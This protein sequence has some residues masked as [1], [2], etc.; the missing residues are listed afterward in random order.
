MIQRIFYPGRFRLSTLLTVVMND[1]PQ[2][3]RSQKFA[4]IKSV[5]LEDSETLAFIISEVLITCLKW[6]AD[7]ITESLI[8]V[9]LS[10]ASISPKTLQMQSEGRVFLLFIELCQRRSEV[11]EGLT[12][13]SLQYPKLLMT[14]DS[15]S[16]VLTI[17]VAKKSL[18]FMVANVSTES[19][20]PVDKL[21]NLTTQLE[22][23]EK[24][25]HMVTSA[26]QTVEHQ[27]TD[28][29]LCLQQ[30]FHHNCDINDANSSW[31]SR[32]I[33]ELASS[34]QSISPAIIDFMQ[35]SM[36]SFD[37]NG[38][39]NDSRS[40]EC[41]RIWLTAC[42]RDEL[43]IE[44]G[45]IWPSNSSTAPLT[46]VQATSN[47]EFSLQGLHTVSHLARSE[48]LRLYSQARSRAVLFSILTSAGG[49]L[50]PS[51]SGLIT[52]ELLP[53]VCTVLLSL[54]S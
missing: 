1:V 8:H 30:S 35:S 33:R 3:Y 23:G 37:R 9:N 31:L 36:L 40:S 46:H 12:A 43:N 6:T 21:I 49:S 48:I 16:D 4:A 20:P 14:R 27:C 29:D 10:S 17:G 41:A 47:K 34:I 18:G 42:F 50:H 51:L 25:L 45:G 24:A 44:W 2:L 5:Q 7:M 13:G 22:I 19:A 39:M 38:D 28:I 26:L 15:S 32:R 11:C 52:E 53:Q 54:H